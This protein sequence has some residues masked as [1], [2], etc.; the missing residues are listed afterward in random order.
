MNAK[1]QR[2]ETTGKAGGVSARLRP[3]RLTSGARLSWNGR[4]LEFVRR[5]AGR[6]LC[7][8]RC[9]GF[10]GQYGP[11]DAGVCVMADR[12]VSRQCALIM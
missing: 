3:A 10:A 1:A 8:M 6:R 2:S 7:V 12:D 4:V 5:D 9:E 11:D